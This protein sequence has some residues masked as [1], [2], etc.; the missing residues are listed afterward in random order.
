MSGAGGAP[1]W[2][3]RA[4][5]VPQWRGKSLAGKTILLH[6][7]QGFGDSIQFVRYVPLVAVKGAKIVLEI[8]DSLMPLVDFR[9]DMVATIKPGAPPPPFDLHCPLMSLPLAFGT[10]LATIPGETPYLCV[11]PERKANVR[12]WLPNSG[13]T[14]V[15]LVWSG[16]P[17]HRNDHNRSIAFDRLAPI[18]SV[19]GC[20]FIS[21]QREYRKADLATLAA[22]PNLLRLDAALADFADTAAVVDALDLVITVDTA[23][24]HLAGALGKPVWI[25][26]AAIQDWRWLLQRDDSPWYPTARLFR[27]PETGDWDSVIALLMRELTGLAR[28]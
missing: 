17:S 23:V 22:C 25:L 24:A 9:D 21:L 18:L 10:T 12:K 5:P 16:K 3:I 13:R 26:L 6:A 11:P 1:L 8:P 4:V 20:A 7:E 15:G 27:Q 28:A 2:R 19:P 14:R